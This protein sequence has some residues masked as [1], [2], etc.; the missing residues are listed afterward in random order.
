MST[1]SSNPSEAE[2]PV[3]GLTVADLAAPAV[4]AVVLVFVV[5]SLGTAATSGPI[6]HR[7][8]VFLQFR[9]CRTLKQSQ[10]LQC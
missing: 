9:A 4:V 6:A 1:E 8:T 7:L 10:L 3:V 5:L 2:G